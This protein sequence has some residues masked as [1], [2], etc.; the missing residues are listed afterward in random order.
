MNEDTIPEVTPERFNQMESDTHILVGVQISSD[1]REEE[2]YDLAQVTR[3]WKWTKQFSDFKIFRLG[4]TSA[5]AQ[6]RRI[7]VKTPEEPKKELSF[8][9]LIFENPTREL[10]LILKE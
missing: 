8:E 4:N 6:E 10:H 1:D 2:R 9:Q 5:K 3:F 7:F